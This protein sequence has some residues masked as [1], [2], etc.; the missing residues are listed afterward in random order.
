MPVY[1]APLKDIRFV[2][3]ELLNA[4]SLTELPGL[5]DTAQTD[6]IDQI[7]E[8][9]GKMCEEVLFPLNMSGDKEG[10][11]YENGVVRTPEGFKEA[12]DMFAQSGWCGVVSDP[13]FGGMGLPHTINFV[14]QEMI[15]SSNMSF[16]MYPGLSAGAYDAIATHG[17]QDQKELYLPKL[18]EG[19]WSGT[20]NLTEPHC[21]TDLGLIKTK[22]VPTDEGDDSF[23]I[24]GQKIFISAGEHDLT[25]NIVHLVLARL[26]DAPEGVKGISLFVVPK[27]LP[28]GEGTNVEVGARNAVT[29]ASIEHKMG[30]KASATCVM[31]YENAKGWLVGKPN[32]GLKAMFT[33]MN[34]ARLG[35]AQQGLG[36]A[37]V[38]YQNGLAYA[39]DRLQM[40]ALDG[41]K[42]P[43]KPAD[44]IIVHP[45]VRRMLL[46]GKAFTEGARALSCWVGMALDKAE[47]SNDEHEKEAAEDLV[48]LMT[49]ILKAYFTDM[50][51]D[52]ASLAMQIHG[53]AG[54]IWEY[55]VEQYTRDAR[56]AMIYEGTNGIQ[57]LDLVGRKMGQN[58]GRALRRFFHPV[59][60]FIEANQ[61]DE[62]MGE[63]VFPLAKAY[64][65]LQQATATIAQKGMA[66]P[67]EAG[68]ASVDYLRQ[69][70]LVAMGYMWAR[71]AKV[72]QDRL[73]EGAS[74]KDFYE[75]KIMTARF[76]MTRML[77]E[78]D[79]RFKMLMAGAEPLMQMPADAF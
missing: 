62:K 29:C 60:A 43:E 54:Y 14:M 23:L 27:F 40:R 16:G 73:A 77:P 57:A 49:P 47:R 12:Y 35:V 2:M 56:I 31:V 70:A 1:T 68:A 30:I 36:I 10:C 52:V 9:G 22:A 45:D 20:M 21:G 71:M 7:L 50:G 26:P 11:H 13:E 44:P 19:T 55:G 33:M 6:L 3:H 79:A 25:E 15:C 53:G 74:D 17:S 5:E 78:T 75:A 42:E 37:E 66:N 32:E 64:A 58:Y 67:N 61:S 18:I 24:S 46:T 51:F 72:A 41:A 69:F 48:A 28:K 63:F 39:K 76:F 65:K 38:A 4:E 59:G 34:A 8:E